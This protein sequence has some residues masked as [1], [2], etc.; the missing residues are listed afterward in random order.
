MTERDSILD[1]LPD[2]DRYSGRTGIRGHK[3][4]L[5]YGLGKNTWLQFAVFRFESKA[6]CNVEL[7]SHRYFR[8]MVRSTSL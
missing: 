2:S 8:I 6:P 4:S 5:Q 7:G 1:I 3:G